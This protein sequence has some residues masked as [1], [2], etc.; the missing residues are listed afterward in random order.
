VSRLVLRRALA[1]GRARAALSAPTVAHADPTAAQRAEAQALFDDA[2]KLMTEKR[3]AEACP[4]LDASQRIDPGLGTLLNLA[5][6]QA[7][8]GKTASAWANFLEAAYQAKAAGQTNRENA[9]RAKATKL[10]PRL[11]RVKIIASEPGAIEL[12]R[13]GVA[14]APSLV[15]TAVPV[16][17][18]EHVIRATAPGKKPWETRIT[19]KDDGQPLTVSVPR[20]DP[21]EVAPPPPPVVALPVAPPPP[22]R[23]VLPPVPVTPPPPAPAP[24]STGRRVGGIVLMVAGAGGL[25]VGAAFAV[26]AKN[27]NAESLTHCPNKP[28]LCDQAGV[29]LRNTALRDGNIATV[30]FV[31]GGVVAAGGLGLVLSSLPGKSPA[32]G[33][34]ATVTAEIEPSGGGWLRVKGSF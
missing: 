6:C 34:S 22:P 4:K 29:D 19:V 9:A 5:E 12:S 8:T 13:D 33:A 1:R 3:F 20:L 21:E 16:D 18:G 23:V 2:R 14:L 11:S 31:V 25:G 26:L 10:E 17:P 28:T 32:S 27:K 7:Q 24:P 30:G 15:G